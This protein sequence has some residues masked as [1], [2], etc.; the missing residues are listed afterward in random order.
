VKTGG[1]S[2]FR[3]QHVYV[4]FEDG[5]ACTGVRSRV[6]GYLSKI[7]ARLPDGA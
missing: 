4:I 1:L 6:L 3:L 7:Q 2:D 5:T